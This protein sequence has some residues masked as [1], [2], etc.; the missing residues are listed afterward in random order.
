V[1]LV[2]VAVKSCHRDFLQL[3]IDSL[4]S[5]E[6]VC[7]PIPGANVPHH[8]H[9]VVPSRVQHAL[10][11]VEAQTPY[12]T[13]TH[14]HMHKHTH[15]C[16]NIHTHMHMLYVEKYNIV[17]RLITG[18]SPASSTET[19]SKIENNKS[20]LLSNQKITGHT[21]NFLFPCKLFKSNLHCQ[22]KVP[23][24][25]DSIKDKFLKGREGTYPSYP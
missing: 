15:T 25:N 11:T 4:V 3:L 13:C 20:G 1:L 22:D 17:Y 14:T 6:F 5:S 24:R 7:R 23:L 16:T 2:H 12:T 19:I 8:D 9:L 10:L 21:N 18:L